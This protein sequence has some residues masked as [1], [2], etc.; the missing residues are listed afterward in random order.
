MTDADDTLRLRADA[1]EWRLVEG[2]IVA[3][4]VRTHT[5]LGINRTGASVWHALVEGA[6][7]DQLVAQLAE[8]FG[9]DRSRAEADLDAFLQGLR[10]HDL[11]ES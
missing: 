3:L 6:T 7:H 2:E 8:S 10:E 4:D 9:V 11:L 1:L 5:Y